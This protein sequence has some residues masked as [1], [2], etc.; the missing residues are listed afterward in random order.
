VIAELLDSRAFTDATRTSPADV[1]AGRLIVTV[2]PQV[3]AVVTLAPEG[4]ALSAGPAPETVAPT[5]IAMARS[6]MWLRNRR[7]TGGIVMSPFCRG[8]PAAIDRYSAWESE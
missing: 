6:R 1:V 3:E 5:T 7:T 4:R 2:V 8:K